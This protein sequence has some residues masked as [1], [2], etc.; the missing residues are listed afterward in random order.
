MSLVFPGYRW[1]DL[2]VSLKNSPHTDP[3]G[4][5]PQIE[6]RDHQQGLPA[7]LPD[8]EAWLTPAR[9]AAC[10]GEPQR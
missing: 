9:R 2:S 1:L 5:G 10:F 8:G 4:L 3:P 6:Y 7:Y